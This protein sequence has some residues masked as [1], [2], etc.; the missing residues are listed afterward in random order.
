MTVRMTGR[1]GHT[2]SEVQGWQ[3]SKV[4]GGKVRGSKA[5]SKLGRTYLVSDWRIWLCSIVQS[6]I[7]P[8]SLSAPFPKASTTSGTT[9]PF[10]WL[11]DF[12][13]ARGNDPIS[14]RLHERD[15]EPD[16]RGGRTL[17]VFHL[18]RP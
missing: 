9:F 10:H 18:E 15:V 8:A 7:F 14:G 12:K 5:G 13:A 17:D 2:G 6:T 11:H 1:G 16:H 3:R 4:R